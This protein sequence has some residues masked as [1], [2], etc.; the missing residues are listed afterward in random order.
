M[1]LMVLRI[2]FGWIFL[3]KMP[4]KIHQNLKKIYQKSVIIITVFSRNGVKI[5]TVFPG[6]AVKS[7]TLFPG[8]AKKSLKLF[9]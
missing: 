9:Q 6:F 4:P 3:P 1:F 8:I 2:D 7:L 5:I